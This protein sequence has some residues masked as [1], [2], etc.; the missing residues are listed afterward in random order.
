MVR[1]PDG[2]N[3]RV[4]YSEEKLT[5]SIKWSTTHAAYLQ[6]ADGHRETG[7]YPDNVLVVVSMVL[8]FVAAQHVAFEG[9]ARTVRSLCGKFTRLVDVLDNVAHHQ[10]DNCKST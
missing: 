10:C 1:E 3:A 6:D 8:R 7:N 9:R 5:T 4:E 2:E